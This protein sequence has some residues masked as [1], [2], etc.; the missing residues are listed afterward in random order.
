MVF[1]IFIFSG[2][3]DVIKRLCFTMNNLNLISKVIFFE[4]VKNML[5]FDG[6]AFNNLDCLIEH[7]NSV[8]VGISTRKV[9]E[10]RDRRLPK[11]GNRYLKVAPRGVEPLS[12]P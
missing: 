3:K 6:I 2:F 7:F 4:E 12:L 1:S 5:C 9:L 8:S 10:T 11:H